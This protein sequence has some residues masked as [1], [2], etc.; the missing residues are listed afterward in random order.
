MAETIA[1]ASNMPALSSRARRALEVLSN[2][3]E[4]KY[5]LERNSFTGRE[6][7]QWRLIAANG[8]KVAGMGHATYHELNNAGLMGHGRPNGFTGSSTSYRLATS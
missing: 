8:G 3:G 6:Q 5:A 2:G 7:F 4:F 1:P